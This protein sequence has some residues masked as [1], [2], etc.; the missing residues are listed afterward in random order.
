M[1]E[2]ADLRTKEVEYKRQLREVYKAYKELFIQAEE[3]LEEMGFFVAPML[4]H[5]DAL[6]HLMRYFTLTDEKEITVEAL[7]QLDKALGHEFRAYFD[8]ADYICITVRSKIA[9]SFKGIPK[10]KIRLKWEQYSEVKRNIVK[11]SDDIAT[12][13]F[14]RSAQ[15]ESIREYEK[16]LKNVFKIYDDFICNIEPLL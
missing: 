6:D 3:K 11:I 15:I 5:R 12:I 2:V 1:S 10:K 13:R 7:E 9:D 16:V 4:E 8:V 14:N